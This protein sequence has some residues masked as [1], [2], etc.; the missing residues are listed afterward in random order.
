M[1]DNHNRST[2]LLEVDSTLLHSEYGAVD[3]RVDKITV[4]PNILT[5]QDT[6]LLTL[7]STQICHHCLSSHPRRF[8]RLQHLEHVVF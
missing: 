1:S 4:I 5:R 8:S 7:N 6:F 2:L 3:R